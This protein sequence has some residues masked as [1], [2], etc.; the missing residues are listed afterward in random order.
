MAAHPGH[1][2]KCIHQT[3]PSTNQPY[4]TNAT[5]LLKRQAAEA[6]SEASCAS[7]LRPSAIARL[8]LTRSTTRTGSCDAWKTAV[9]RSHHLRGRSQFLHWDQLLPKK[10]AHASPTATLPIVL[11]SAAERI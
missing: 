7:T 9:T 6:V 2:S 5:V 10:K 8:R 1:A 4:W 3:M 11:K